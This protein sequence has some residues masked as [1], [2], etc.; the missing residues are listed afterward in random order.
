MDEGPGNLPVVFT[1]MA[2]RMAKQSLADNGFPDAA[3]RLSIVGGGCSGYQ[4]QMQPLPLEEV[5]TTDTS[6]VF[7]DLTVVVDTMSLLLLTGT[8]VDY[9]TTLQS[10]GFVFINPN[11]K[12]KCGCGHSFS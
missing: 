2:A 4:Y 12:R 9:K 3:L 11:A 10:S 7:E 5:K 6:L 1:E 8:T